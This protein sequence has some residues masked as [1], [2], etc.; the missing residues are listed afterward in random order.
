MKVKLMSDLHL[1]FFVDRNTFDPGTGDVLILAGD[2]CIASQYD[3]YHVFFEKCVKGYQR[4]LYVMGNHEHYEGDY[5]KT[6]LHLRKNLP[7]EIT[8]L[9]NTSVLID[10]VHFVGA[11]LWTNFNNLD[12]QTIEQARQCMNDYHCVENLQ[13]ED[14]IDAHL[15]TRQWFESCVPML[16]GP[17]FMI[18]HHLPSFQSVKGRYEET[19]GM[20]ATNLEKFIKANDNIKYWAHG[21]CHHTSDYMIGDCRVIANP[22]GYQ[23]YEV[24]PLFD[25]NFE[26]E[27]SEKDCPILV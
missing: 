22:R 4:V 24:N 9:N 3:D 2:I 21:H 12:S 20:Y 7:K 13:P 16:R 25:P 26:I 17:V 19:A 8:L 10:G 6:W 15:F 1:E 11:T 18:T 23:D 14:T 27:V 5:N